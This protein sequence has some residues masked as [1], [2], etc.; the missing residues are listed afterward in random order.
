MALFNCPNCNSQISDKADACPNCGTNLEKNKK[1]KTIIC[2][3]C[4]TEI[5]TKTKKCPNCGCPVTKKKKI[6]IILISIFAI[7]AICG[8][9]F[10]YLFLNDYLP[11]T[12][13]NNSSTNSNTSSENIEIQLEDYELAAVKLIGEIK[14]R[15]KD[16]DSMKIHS[17]R[18]KQFYEG[19]R[20]YHFE[21]DYTA[22]NGF[23]GANRETQYIEKGQYDTLDKYDFDTM[24]MALEKSHF[25]ENSYVMDETLDVDKLL[26]YMET[27]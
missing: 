6:I 25:K 17:L 9:V 19:E 26:K 23:G 4:K 5:P 16:P 1:T 13:D 22:M 15:L 8:G 12:I 24:I 18:V 14:D 27:H 3:E 10:A 7:L 2:K 20:N 21:I 11:F